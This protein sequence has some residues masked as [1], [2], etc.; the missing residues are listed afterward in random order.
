MA[1]DSGQTK[2]PFST[3]L[4]RSTLARLRARADRTGVAR[5]A[6]AE[7]YIAEGLRMDEHPLIC[8][9]EGAG[10]RRP[11]LIGTRLDVAQVIETIRQNENSVDAAAEYLDLP[12]SH[13]DACVAYYVA[14]QD[15]TDAWITRTRDAAQEAEIAWLSP[16]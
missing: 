16:G 15:E 11:A 6:L 2:E 12:P 14:Y 5:T 4:S 8:F 9:R 1:R 7:R 3:R 13:V 10:G